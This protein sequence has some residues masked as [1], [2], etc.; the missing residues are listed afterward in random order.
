LGSLGCLES[1]Q[2]IACVGGYACSSLAST[3]SVLCA[4]QLPLHL[5]PAKI[6]ALQALP[7]LGN[8]KIDI[9]SLTKLAQQEFWAGR[10]VK[11]LDSLGQMRMVKQ[12][13]ACELQ[14]MAAMRAIAASIIVIFHWYWF[15]FWDQL[16]FMTDADDWLMQGSAWFRIPLYTLMVSSWPLDVFVMLSGYSDSTDEATTPALRRRSNCCIALLFLACYWPFPSLFLWIHNTILGNHA[17]SIVFFDGSHRWYLV[18]YLV[19]QALHSWVFVPLRELSC[20]HQ[21]ACR[22]L[23]GCVIVTVY[24]TGCH[25][26]QMR[27]WQEFPFNACALGSPDWLTTLAQ[28]FLVDTRKLPAEMG[29]WFC[30]LLRF[31]EVD[32]LVKYTV[33]W[34]FGPSLV[35]YVRRSSWRSLLGRFGPAPWTGAFVLTLCAQKQFKPDGFLL[36]LMADLST[37]MWFITAVALASARSWFPLSFWVWLGSFSTSTYI[38]HVYLMVGGDVDFFAHQGK[39]IIPTMKTAVTA[40][41]N[42]P[43]NTFAR[44]AILLAYPLV[45]AA[46]LAP[47]FQ[48]AWNMAFGIIETA[49]FRMQACCRRIC[50][51]SKTCT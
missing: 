44:F 17:T 2:L 13:H 21:M 33:C 48:F 11:S 4:E 39:Q 27:S 29:G 43:G 16:M 9:V 3:V 38:F 14:T 46:T 12:E 50:T 23:P 42:W 51:A 15:D 34:W 5:R 32:L 30:P 36:C 1:E 41:G 35:S 8:G 6:L 26:S 28:W 45:F 20:H 40:V 49:V 18:Y 10:Y 7:K 24:C 31:A 22:L 19:C 37:T 25:I 47:I